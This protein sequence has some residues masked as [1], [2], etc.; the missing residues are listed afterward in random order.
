MPEQKEKPVFTIQ[1]QQGADS[2]ARCSWCGTDPLY[3]AYHDEEWGMPQRDP[4]R[5][6]EKMCLE[7][8]QAG[9]SW[10][11]ILRKRPAFRTAFASFVAEEMAAF[12]QADVERLV[13]DAG[14]IRHRGK[15]EAVIHNAQLVTQRFAQEGSLTEFLWSYAPKQHTPLQ[16]D[17]IPSTSAESHALSR[18]LRKLGFKFVGPTTMYAFMQATGMVNDHLP[19][20]H[21]YEKVEIA[22]GRGETY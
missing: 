8:F 10:I 18:D 13:L 3:M 6:F 16:P 5:L 14:I 12:T 19:G 11:T 15:I 2:L 22:C 9:L 17:N 20:C 7:G 4:V 1:L 21:C